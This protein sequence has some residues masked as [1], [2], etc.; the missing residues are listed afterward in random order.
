M[1]II[2]NLL[3]GVCRRKA[4]VIIKSKKCFLRP[5]TALVT[6]KREAPKPYQIFRCCRSVQAPEGL[7]FGFIKIYFHAY[8]IK[9]AKLRPQA[10]AVFVTDW[11]AVHANCLAAHAGFGK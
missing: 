9:D 2:T 4:T 7:V 3:Q 10:E 5:C 6:A 8:K 1:S 11:R